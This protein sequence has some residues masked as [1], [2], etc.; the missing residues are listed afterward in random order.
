MDKETLSHYGW[1]VILVL[2]LSVLLALATP[3]GGYIK[4]AINST[5]AGFADVNNAALGQAGLLSGVIPNGGKYITGYEY[6]NDEWDDSNIT[7][8]NP[9]D[10][11]PEE[12]K[13]GDVYLYGD[14]EYRYNA[15]AETDYVLDASGNIV[16]DDQHNPQLENTWYPFDEW[17]YY[18]SIPEGW[19]M[20]YCAFDKE[21]PSN[22]LTNING[23]NVTCAIKT[24]FMHTEIKSAPVVPDTVTNM[25]YAFS[26]CENLQT[27]PRLPSALDEA[28]FCFF[29]NYELANVPD[30][31]HCTAL[32]TTEDM[33]ENCYK[34][35]KLPAVPSSIV[36]ATSMFAYC[37]GLVDASDF[38]IPA[39]IVEA[40]DMFGYCNNLKY[41]PVIPETTTSIWRMFRGCTSLE[42]VTINSTLT[43]YTEAFKNVDMSKVTISGTCPSNIKQAAA[44]TGKNGSQVTIIN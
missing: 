29:D 34:L 15:Y 12:P 21:T 13:D 36:E 1:I 16:F 33:F 44:N 14:Y 35:T 11:F 20:R 30:F 37:K 23:K 2:I 31:T 24:W 10:K 39:N 42:K 3:F 22:P 19:G 43:K 7:I 9:G 18:C 17:W 40:Y 27:A 38:V 4:A 25:S 28:A 32:F 26:R 8:L 6:A 5:T 41:A